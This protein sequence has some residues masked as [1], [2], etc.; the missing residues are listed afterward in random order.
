MTTGDDLLLIAIDPWSLRIRAE[1][2]VRFALRAAELAD[3]GLAGRIVVGGRR[4]EVVDPARVEDRRLSNVL[5]SLR[6]AA[7][8]PTL[9]DW[10]RGAPRSLP[11]EYLSRLEDQKAARVRRSRDRGGRRRSEI[12]AID[13]DR[14]SELLARLDTVVRPGRGTA[15]PA[16]RDL[17][18]AVLVQAAGLAPAAYPGW[19]GIPARRRMA[20]LAAADRLAPATG[21]AAAA[22]DEELAEAVAAGSDFL[23]REL[24]DELSNVYA[25]LS[26]GGSGLGHDLDAGSWSGGGHHGGGQH[27][28]GH[29]AGGDGGG[30]HSGG[31]D[32]GGHGW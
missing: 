29:H 32:G 16:A 5:H 23:S 20:A 26:T 11:T 28:G 17:T 3:L 24:F 9:K 13:H 27:G 6:V 31:H 10:L 19:R 8:P 14:R 4:I 15:P 30:H 22:V 12:L 7:P 2:R 18:L 25:D 21:G 1:G